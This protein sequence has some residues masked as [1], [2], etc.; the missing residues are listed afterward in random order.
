MTEDIGAS[1]GER[2]RFVYVVYHLGGA[3]H[4]YP[5]TAA[6]LRQIPGVTLP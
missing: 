6:M 3:V 1:K 4:G 2:T 5:I